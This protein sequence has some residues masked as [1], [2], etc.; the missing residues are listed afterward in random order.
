MVEKIIKEATSKSPDGK[1]SKADFQNMASK[2]T[3]YVLFSPMEVDIIFHFASGLNGGSSSVGPTGT[4]GGIMSGAGGS[5]GGKSTIQDGRL[6]VADFGQLLDPKWNPGMIAGGDG[7]EGK[8]KLSALEELF[9]GVY[10]FGLG[11]IA[12][13][14]EFYVP[15]FRSS[16]LWG[17]CRRD[18]VCL[19]LCFPSG[20]EK[21]N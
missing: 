1:I 7:D 19:L 20:F 5:G 3:R 4:G 14:G 16:G 6:S 10:K 21:K 2:S 9:R 11:G 18:E 8:P 17:S 12:G 13:A 15:F